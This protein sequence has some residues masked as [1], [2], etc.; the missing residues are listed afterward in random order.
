M[1]TV[2]KYQ[3]QVTLQG[4]PSV[5]A[6]GA[7]TPEALGAGVAIAEGKLGA[8]TAEGSAAVDSAVGQLAGA[9][10]TI[11]G[12]VYQKMRDE[13]RRQADNVAILRA[14]N[15]LSDVENDLL[16]HPEHGALAVRGEAA[17][18]LPEQ[19]MGGFDK[20]AASIAQTLTTPEQQR[21]FA[22]LAASH[23]QNVS[24]IITRHTFNEIQTLHANELKSFLDNTTSAVV[25]NAADSY[26]VGVKLREGEVA[27][28][29]NADHFGLGPEQVEAEVSDFQSKAHAAVIDELSARDMD[30]QAQTYFKAVR[31]Q[32]GA[33]ELPHVERQIEASTLRTDSQRKADEIIQSGGSPSEQRAAVR[34]IQ[35]GKLRD[36]VEQRVETNLTN[37]IRSQSQSLADTIIATHSDLTDQRTAAKDIADPDVRDHALQYIEHEAD[38]A[39]K[40]KR[41]TDETNMRSAYDV[42][43]RTRNLRA[44]PAATWATFSGPTRHALRS[45]ADALAV[46][47]PVRT[48]RDTYDQLIKLSTS[49]PSSFTNVNL[50]Q[51]RHTLDD[52]D[53]KMFEHA[54]QQLRAGNTEAAQQELAPFQTRQEVFTSTLQQYGIDPHPKTDTDE[55]KAASAAIAELNRLV[56]S[57]VD[58]LQRPARG[59]AGEVLPGIRVKPED[60]RSIVDDLLTQQINVGGGGGGWD[61]VTAIKGAALQFIGQRAGAARA[62]ADA[63]IPVTGGTTKPLMSV[64]VNDVPPADR[65]LIESAMRQTGIP[66]NDVTV[67]NLYLEDQLRA[68]RREQFRRSDEM[69]EQLRRP[70]P[71]PPAPPVPTP[72]PA[73]TPAAGPSVLGMGLTGLSAAARAAGDFLGRTPL[74]V[75]GG[76]NDVAP[77][78]AAPAKAEPKPAPQPANPPSALGA[79][80]VTDDIGSLLSIVND[81]PNP[82]AQT[83]TT[84]DQVPAAERARIVGLLKQAHVRVTDENILA[85]WMRDRRQ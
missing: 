56:N 23:R 62:F 8:A 17:L 80:S 47:T 84:I 38:V 60:I 68:R 21:Q 20:Q 35:D 24:G 50:L 41:D 40:V 22:A 43:D 44:I 18:S 78:A 26:Q 77:P 67:L 4:I 15:A 54:Q 7:E 58:A 51:Y 29:R 42:L 27:I 85:R 64:T 65:A 16:Y 55:G 37:V 76:L 83:H 49:D 63:V 75:A 3:R 28:R 34:G 70:L 1:P 69:N 59:K 10:A 48:D 31:D 14:G 71:K 5:R 9:G 2:P 66:V 81:K 45:Y 11:A 36:L 61:W 74:V 39:D 72:R 57:R 30:S 33:A 6:T 82:F 53:F 52:G 19:M 73:A 32:L 79:A 46:G 13:S 12:D 25:Q